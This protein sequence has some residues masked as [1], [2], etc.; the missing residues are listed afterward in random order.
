MIPGRSLDSIEPGVKLVET[1]SFKVDR[2]KDKRLLQLVDGLISESR[3]T[4]S[5]KLVG[6]RCG[7]MTAPLG[8][9]NGAKLGTQ[10]LRLQPVLKPGGSRGR[11]PIGL[12]P[13]AYCRFIS[14]RRAVNLES[15]R[16]KS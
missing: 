3:R 1:V 5:L 9:E 11:S 14:S 4:W 16:T 15:G 12:H 6:P 8:P 2:R 13:V 10:E 7:V